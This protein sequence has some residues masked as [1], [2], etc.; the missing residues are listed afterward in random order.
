MKAPD[1]S[2]SHSRR[3]AG[4]RV[5]TRRRLGAH[6]GAMLIL[7]CAALAGPAL[8]R[9]AIA[10]P[11]PANSERAAAGQGGGSLESAAAKAG[12]TGRAVAMSLIGLAF[13][14]AAIVLAFRRDFKEAAGVFAVG[15]V[16]V[17]LATP[18]GV[19]LLQDTVNSLFGS[20]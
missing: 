15:I 11:S 8:A 13:A 4:S 19:S 17:L 10:T 6:A 9:G 1:R 16:S 3:P 7:A 2:I 18:T 20:H 14:V 12:S 5:R